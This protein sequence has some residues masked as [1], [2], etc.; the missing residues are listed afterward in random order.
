MYSLEA[1]LV[2]DSRPDSGGRVSL[3]AGEALR[4]EQQVHE[5]HVGR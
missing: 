1:V 5:L 4:V 2:I 3:V